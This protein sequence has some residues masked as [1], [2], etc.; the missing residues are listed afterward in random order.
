MMNNLLRSEVS[1][2]WATRG[3]LARAID[4]KSWACCRPFTSLV[5]EIAIAVTML[6]PLEVKTFE[7]LNQHVGVSEEFIALV[8]SPSYLKALFCSFFF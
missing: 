8:N 7:R 1:I 2:D 5:K 6:R 4:R 3:E